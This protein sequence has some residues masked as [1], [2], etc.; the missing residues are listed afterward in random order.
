[1]L[2]LQRCL[3]ARLRMGLARTVRSREDEALV[4]V[5]DVIVVQV[6]RMVLFQMGPAA[7]VRRGDEGHAFVLHRLVQD[8]LHVHRA[9]HV[10]FH[11]NRV[12]AGLAGTDAIL[13]HLVQDALYVPK[14]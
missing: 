8:L 10:L 14:L 3:L 1:M 11:I 6:L 2:L 13:R 7:L 12:G 9:T 4:H 5:G